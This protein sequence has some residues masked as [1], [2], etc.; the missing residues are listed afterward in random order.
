MRWYQALNELD[1]FVRES[2]E[3]RI[4]GDVIAIP[5][6]TRP[7]LYRCFD[8]VRTTFLEERFSNPLNES[9]CLSEVYT[10]I[11]RDILDRLG[12]D[13]VSMPVGLDRFL[14]DPTNQLI[15]G[16]FDPLFDLLKK[17]I[18]VETFA[19]KAS[20]SIERTL[21]DLFPPGY[22]KWVVLNLID[23]FRPKKSF[24]VSLRQP[25]SKEVM[26]RLPTSEEP[27]PLPAESK[28][29]CFE[30]E[31]VP[32]LTVPDFIV[33]AAEI[34][35]CLAVRSDFKHAI[36]IAANASEKG[37]WCPFDSLRRTDD[38]IDLKGCL[39][40][41]VAGCPDDL[42]LVADSKR[43]LR[44]ELIVECMLEDHWHEREELKKVKH[45]HDFLRP[46]LGSCV[47][48]R[49]P[50]PQGVREA[51]GP[52]FRLLVVGFEGSRLTPLVDGLR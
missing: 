16:L 37:D 2:R 12:L 41:Y 45:R 6:E 52:D 7:E 14:R 39:M 3:I 33:C 22:E 49:S 38:P 8:A 4:D 19:A 42:A 25:T 29:L 10:R 46:P 26:K 43:V 1:H 24:S 27:L 21:R 36:W 11:E 23:L 32:I 5:E 15:R 18:D 40:V 20:T 17:G 31:G 35:R 44:P 51:L 28:Q 34:N 30:H 13:R 47:I 50:A 48:S 9:R